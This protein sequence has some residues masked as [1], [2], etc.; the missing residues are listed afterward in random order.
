[1]TDR[2]RLA[3]LE[4]GDPPD[5]F[6]DPAGALTEPNGLVA[7]GGDLSVERLVAA[8]RRGI[9]PWSSEGQPL[10][11]WCPD[12]RSVLFPADFHTSRSL[13]R[14][15]RSGGFEVSANQRFGDVI[16]QCAALRAASGTWLTPDMIT[17]YERLHAL[18]L[19]HSVE[20]WQD[21]EL[22]GGIY[23]VGLG[24][25]FFGESMFSARRDGSK[26]AMA[27]LVRIA[28]REGIAVVDC[29][30]HNPHLGRLG[31][32]TI[33]RR[34]F[35]DILRRESV[36]QPLARVRPEGRRPASELA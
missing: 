24:G 19:A 30:V 28:L 15:L 31:A 35:L 1:M 20:A 8:Y 13:R 6:P 5:A 4:P 3:W 18:G 34:E 23:G 36:R 21:G 2:P 29:Q 16:R 25:V 22:A 7:A 26:V 9:F 33:P 17:A 27:A 10:L 14:T 11:W 12:P 32:G